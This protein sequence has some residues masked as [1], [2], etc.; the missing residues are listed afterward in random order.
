MGLCG[1]VKPGREWVR[2]GGAGPHLSNRCTEEASS[3][4][5]EIAIDAQIFCTFASVG[6]ERRASR[7]KETTSDAWRTLFYGA[8]ARLRFHAAKTHCGHS[9]ACAFGRRADLVL[10]P[11]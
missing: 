6:A 9:E 5:C 3:S 7:Q 10:A 8:A 4:S 1:E 11:R 2:T